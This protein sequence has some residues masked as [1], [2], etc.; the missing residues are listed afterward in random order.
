MGQVIEA[1]EKTG[2]MARTNIVLLGD[3][4]QLPCEQMFHLNSLF[5]DKGWLTQSGGVVTSYQVY[6]AQCGLSAQIYLQPHVDRQKVYQELL[7]VQKEYAPYIR[8]VF[9]K[10][11][12]A[13]LHLTGEFDFVI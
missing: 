9:T 13:D 8:R 7:Q 5:R 11:E 3:H 6:A 12:A 4:G 2:G 10:Q 1:L